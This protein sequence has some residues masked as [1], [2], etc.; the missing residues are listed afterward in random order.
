MSSRYGSALAVSLL[1]LAIG[2]GCIPKSTSGQEQAS[3]DTN[4]RI[5]QVNALVASVTSAPPEF[6]A[7]LLIRIAE[8][9]LLGNKKKRAE[10]LE[11]AF[12]QSSDAQQKIRRK[13]WAGPVDTRS[14]YLSAAYDL[15]LDELSLKSRVIKVMV[16]LDPQRARTLFGEIPKIKLTPLSCEDAL[17]Y[18]VSEFYEALRVIDEKSFT[19]E[20]REQAENVR[21]V[22]SYIDELASPAQ[23]GLTVNL[24]ADL[25]VR[26]EELTMLVS[27]LTLRLKK[28]SNDPRSFAVSMRHGEVISSFE[29]LLSE[30]ET[31]NV[32][33]KDLLSSL[34]TYMISQ[35][36]SA[37]CSDALFNG[38]PHDKKADDIAY[39]NKWFN[40]PIAPDD[41]K[42]LRVGSAEERAPF[43]TSVNSARLLMRVKSLRFGTKSTPLSVKERSTVEWEQDLLDVLS[44]VE[45]WDVT[46]EKTELDYFHEKCNLYVAL[47]NLAPADE[48]RARVL[49]S[50]ASYLRNTAI[51]ERSRI[52]WWLHAKDLLERMSKLDLPRRSKMLEI[53]RNAGD[54]TL[55]LYA[56]LNDLL[57]GYSNAGS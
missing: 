16:T 43:W 4:K 40:V 3:K 57:S 10:I 33:T 36:H 31:K 26:S 5:E 14:G 18:D 48:S 13:V 2:N 21:F 46:T 1:T 17:G 12:R 56:T 37:Q 42:P 7:D 23:V 35:L 55:Q 49:L 19:N 27:S 47:F 53:S 41:V 32:P 9:D 34:R 38:S 22:Q 28:I 29:R 54:A 15:R 51:K 52:E 25:Q 6:S 20:E 30:C 50:L 45:S 44:A 24:I 39:I 8:S 11:D